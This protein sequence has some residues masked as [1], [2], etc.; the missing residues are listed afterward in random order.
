MYAQRAVDMGHDGRG[1]E[2]IH[3]GLF[4]HTTSKQGGQQCKTQIMG[5]A[6]RAESGGQQAGEGLQGSVG[7]RYRVQNVTNNAR[8]QTQAFTPLAASPKSQRGKKSAW[9]IRP[10]A[11]PD[12]QCPELVAG[13]IWEL[14]TFWKKQSVFHN[15]D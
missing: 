8:D 7:L 4:G 10:L 14:Q 15:I 5:N 13:A 3:D 9:S 11:S 1:R 2:P 6:A 12:Q